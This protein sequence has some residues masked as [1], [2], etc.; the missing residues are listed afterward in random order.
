MCNRRACI[1]LVGM[2]SDQRWNRSY[3][4]KTG[5]EESIPNKGN[6]KRYDRNSQQRTTRTSMT[7]ANVGSVLCS[8]EGDL[9][10]INTAYFGCKRQDSIQTGLQREETALAHTTESQAEDLIWGSTGS[11]CLN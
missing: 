10:W 9:L 4:S 7:R 11:G 2:L 3:P 6:L 8:S 1:G 5:E